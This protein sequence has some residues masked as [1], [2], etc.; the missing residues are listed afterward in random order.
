MFEEYQHESGVTQKAILD[1]YIKV[2]WVEWIGL[3]GI[4]S[5]RMGLGTEDRKTG[6]IVVDTAKYYRYGLVLLSGGKET[7]KKRKEG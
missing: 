5:V 6:K 4:E 1:R 2:A 3:N 7:Q